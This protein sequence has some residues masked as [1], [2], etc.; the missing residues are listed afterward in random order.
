MKR[1][2]TRDTE[3]GGVPLRAGEEVFLAY[4]SGSR[5]V[6][7]FASPD[8]VDLD[9]SWAVPHL[10]FGQ[11]VHACLG[12]PLARLLLRVEL[13]VLHERLPDLRLGRAARRAGTDR[14]SPR[15][16]AWWPCPWRGRRCRSPSRCHHAF[17][18]SRRAARDPGDGGRP[19]RPDSRRRRT[20]ADQRRA[21]TD[22]GVGARRAYRPGTARR[23]AA[24]VLTVRSARSRRAAD[25]RPPR[26]G[27]PRRVGRRPRP[28]AGGRPAA[29]PRPAQPL[30][31]AAGV[32][33]FCSSRAASASP[34]C[35][36]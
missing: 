35:C 15:V 34:R 17:D 2:V 22:P 33:P 16:A 31:A 20:D 1:L 6:G 8:E 23:R 29:D 7:R 24:A 9:R 25:R 26:G 30:P 18:H 14:W 5:D 13:D 12:A 4:A 19:P 11:G 32:E 3:L 28:G 36:P 10:G 27:R 21:R